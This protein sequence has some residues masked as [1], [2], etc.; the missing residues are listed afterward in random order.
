ME[1][2]DFSFEECNV[3]NGAPAGLET[4]LSV[5]GPE[6]EDA[7]MVIGE[8]DESPVGRG[9]RPVEVG[10]D[11]RAGRGGEADGGACDG[12]DNGGPIAGV[13]IDGD[14]VTGAEANE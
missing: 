2:I 5:A 6:G 14:Q 11:D 1:C 4:P 13:V 12:V 8:G 9:W 10:E 7:S 3:V